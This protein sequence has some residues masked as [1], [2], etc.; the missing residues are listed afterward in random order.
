MDQHGSTPASKPTTHG[1]VNQQVGNQ[2]AEAPP[3]PG[4]ITKAAQRCGDLRKSQP[5]CSG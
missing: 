5:Q 1:E 4:Q 2:D 3:R